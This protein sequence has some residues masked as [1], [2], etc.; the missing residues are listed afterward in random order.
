ML[1]MLALAVAFT[2][3]VRAACLCD[4]AYITLRTIDNWVHGYGLRWNIG[5]RVQTYTHPLWMFL[6]SSVY[7][8]TREPYYTTL[9]VCLVAT[10]ATLLLVAFVL[11]PSRDFGAL[12][13][14]VLASSH[15][16][17]T[18]STTGF[19]NSLANLLLVIFVLELDR[20]P[21]PA[22]LQRLTFV[23]AL[24]CLTRQDFVLLVGPAILVE[25]AVL[26]SRA[27]ARALVIGGLPIIAWELFSFYY[28]GALVP[29][30]A[31]AKLHHHVARGVVLAQGF[32]WL[33]FTL[34]ND[35]STAL[36]VLWA[37]IVALW[38]RERTV[39]WG[40]IRRASLSRL[41]LCNWLAII[42]QGAYGLPPMWFSAWRCSCDAS[43]TKWQPDWV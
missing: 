9:A 17:T 6:L 32:R 14:V 13:V 29:N 1:A 12:G 30:T 4:D 26:R 15:A 31:A 19:E 5:E 2:G 11:P 37:A 41:L 24:L 16:F 21:A 22:Q 42:P 25:L 18:Y 38:R 35:W 27:A 7:Y 39:V 3:V 28:Y 43:T 8:F 20:Q 10:A 23:A 40:L 34:K 36:V 33:G